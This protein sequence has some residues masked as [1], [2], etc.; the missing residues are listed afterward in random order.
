MP[1]AMEPMYG[2]NYEYPISPEMDSTQQAFSRSAPHPPPPKTPT[3]A[4]SNGSKTAGS[5]ES[6]ATVCAGLRPGAGR[7]DVALHLGRE[8]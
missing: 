1:R 7:F 8:S 3:R 6:Q 2:T 5:T 4:D